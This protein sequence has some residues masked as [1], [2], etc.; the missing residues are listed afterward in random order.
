MEVY[1][2]NFPTT[3]NIDKWT[4]TPVW[5]REEKSPTQLKIEEMESSV[6]ELQKQINELKQ[7]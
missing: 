1:I 2:P 4:L 5:K 3:L 6:A 7:M